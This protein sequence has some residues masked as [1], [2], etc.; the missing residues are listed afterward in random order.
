MKT[1]DSKEKRMR[2]LHLCRGSWSPLGFAEVAS[3]D[4]S[5]IL[6][7]QQERC[8]IG[9]GDSS[10]VILRIRRF[11]LQDGFHFDSRRDGKLGCLRA[12]MLV[13]RLFQ[14]SPPS[15]RCA[16]PWL[17]RGEDVVPVWEPHRLLRRRRRWHGVVGV[18]RACHAGAHSSG[19]VGGGG[20]QAVLELF[21]WGKD[22]E[23][24]HLFR[25]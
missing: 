3:L 12:A 16:W 10:H 4:Q 23:G 15:G 20:R 21:R 1:N 19:L 17:W 24:H 6:P 25:R 7:I 13:L 11:G 2:G 18:G 22:G 5:S 9:A 8:H 14:I